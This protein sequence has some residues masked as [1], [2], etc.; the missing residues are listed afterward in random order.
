[1][2]LFKLSPNEPG[3]K[4]EDLNAGLYRRVN[5]KIANKIANI[6]KNT[7]ITPNHL[8]LLLFLLN[9]IIAYFFFRYT[10]TYNIV[11]GILLLI[12]YLIDQIN[13]SLARIQNKASD[14]GTWYDHIN[15]AFG[16][17][18]IL[19]AIAIG[20]FHST[21]DYRIFIFAFASLS[22]YLFK[23]I[24]LNLYKTLRPNQNTTES[25]KKNKLI[26]MFIRN[27]SYDGVFIVP[28]LSILSFLNQTNIALV[29]LAVYG[30]IFIIIQY[31]YL[32]EKLR[33]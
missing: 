27:F 20:V 24:M 29:F 5:R 3:N 14:L 11:A 25:L 28:I 21:K 2:K 19:I 7:F 12:Y 23:D 30:W 31:V 6:L 9:F 22:A 18:L 1:M 16:L 15:D 33:E 13:G 32:A 8:T 26:G 17:T 10:K 4:A